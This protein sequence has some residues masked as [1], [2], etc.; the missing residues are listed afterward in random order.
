MNV[1]SACTNP[2]SGCTN[3]QASLVMISDPLIC[4]QSW[5]L[6]G[7]DLSDAMAHKRRCHTHTRVA[8]H[9]DCDTPSGSERC[10]QC[11]EPCVRS[12]LL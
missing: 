8:Y 11:S 4:L 9:I 5:F 1:A 2:A 7:L 3:H 6:V 12:S 10:T